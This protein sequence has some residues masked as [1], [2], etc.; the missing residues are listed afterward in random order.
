MCQWGSVT[1]QMA[2]PVPSISWCVSYQLKEIC[3]EKNA[4]AFNRD[5][6][7]HLVLCL[8]LIPFHWKN[9]LLNWRPAVG[10]QK[11]SWTN[12]ASAFGRKPFG[13]LTL[14][15]MLEQSCWAIDCWPDDE[16]KQ[17]VGQIVCLP[18][19]HHPGVNLT[20]LFWHELTNSIL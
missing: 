15:L 2:V 4:L 6:C 17:Y 20:K 5:R 18:N 7:C 13:R 9:V 12:G 10:L 8:Q 3:N 19:T 1:H 16:T 14:H 11:R